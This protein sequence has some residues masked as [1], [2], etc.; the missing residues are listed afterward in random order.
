MEYKKIG[1]LEIPSIGFGTYRLKGT[2]AMKAVLSALKMGY[3]HIDTAEYYDNEEMVGKAIKKSN[4]DREKIFLT[5]KI[6][7]TNLRYEDVK[8]SF[9]DSLN[10]LNTEYIDL[11]LIHWPNPDIELKETIKAMNELQDSDQVR[12]IGVSNF[13]VNLMKK[14]IKHSKY[15]ITTN[16][17]EY[18]PFKKQTEILDFC[19]NKNIILTAYS[20]L[21]KGKVTENN[22]LKKIGDKYDK[23]ASQITLRWQI[24][25]KNVIA[26]PKASKKS[27]REENIDI[28]DFKLTEKEIN[29]INEINR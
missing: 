2:E 9:K 25:Q 17:V 22:V 16:Q 6:W 1:G 12:H 14:A 8:N 13:D 19:R 18:H 20:P 21:A 24:Q 5:T 10:K 23:T 15:P 7:K 29:K 27:H 11:L 26:I 28:F 4:I 3:R